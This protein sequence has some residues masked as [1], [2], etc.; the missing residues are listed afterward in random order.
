[1]AGDQTHWFDGLPFAGLNGDGAQKHW[2]DGLPHPEL[3][4]ATP[5]AP[6][7]TDIGFWLNG[8]VAID[9]IAENMG[10]LG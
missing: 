1:M 5:V 3:V 2:F 7:I 4:A 6:T 8:A 10:V 9:A